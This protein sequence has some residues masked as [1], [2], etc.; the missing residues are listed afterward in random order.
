[1]SLFR[2]YR[3]RSPTQR[4]WRDSVNEEMMRKAESTDRRRCAGVPVRAR[5]ADPRPAN[6]CIGMLLLSKGFCPFPGLT[7]FFNAVPRAA[8]R[9]RPLPDEPDVSRLWPLNAHSYGQWPFCISMSKGNRSS[10][11]QRTVIA[12]FD[13]ICGRDKA[14]IPSDLAKYFLLWASGESTCKCP[15]PHRSLSSID[16]LIDWS[17]NYSLECFCAV[18]LVSAVSY[19]LLPYF[20]AGNNREYCELICSLD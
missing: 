8:A 9:G 17:I 18:I 2:V 19:S 12:L 6:G 14:L 1:M 16:W 3:H 13:H 5:S 10:P 15:S 4:S 20:A 11:V 7:R